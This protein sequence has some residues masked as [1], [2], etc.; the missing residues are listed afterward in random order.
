MNIPPSGLAVLDPEE[1]DG[2]CWRLEK[3]RKKRRAELKTCTPF[4]IEVRFSE[5]RRQKL[6]NNPINETHAHCTQSAHPA[7]TPTGGLMRAAD[8]RDRRGGLLLAR[9]GNET[10]TSN[11]AV[12]ADMHR[13]RRAPIGE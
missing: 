4:E 12:S 13:K 8:A 5:L 9:S 2:W 7:C 11:L 6:D 3:S 1:V 10:A